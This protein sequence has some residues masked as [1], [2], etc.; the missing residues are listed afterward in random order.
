MMVKVSSFPEALTP[1][2]FLASIFLRQKL[3][4][5]WNPATAIPTK[6]LKLDNF[7]KRLSEIN[8]SPTKSQLDSMAFEGSITSS[9]TTISLHEDGCQTPPKFLKWDN[10]KVIE[11]EGR[12][13]NEV[14]KP[15]ERKDKWL[16]QRTNFCQHIHSLPR[17]PKFLKQDIWKVVEGEGRENNEVQEHKHMLLSSN[18]FEMHTLAN[19]QCQSHKCRKKLTAGSF[20]R[21]PTDSFLKITS[22][23]RYKVQAAYCGRWE[24]LWSPL[25]S[26]FESLITTGNSASVTTPTANT[27]LTTQSFFRSIASSCARWEACPFIRFE[28]PLL[29]F[30]PNLST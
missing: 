3:I 8:S 24:A 16:Y 27:W 23:Y 18:Q 5:F 28:A 30:F 9:L 20:V 12:E 2:P 1:C 17:P 15:W 25:S 26:S 19:M 4:S 29:C 11:C 7:L 13:N 10:W 22:W 6:L 14:Q 21:S